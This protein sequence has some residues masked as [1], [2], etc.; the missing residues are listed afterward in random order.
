MRALFSLLCLLSTILFGNPTTTK[1]QDYWEYHELIN[2]AEKHISNENF[3]EALELY[4]LTFASYDFVFIRDYKIAAQLAVYLNEKEKAFEI[5][6]KGI[7]AGWDF[8][9]LKRN[10]YLS[11]LKGE[12]EWKLL[13]KAYPELRK[14]YLKSI[15]LVTKERVR[16]MFKE[17]QR[18]ALGAL[19]RIGDKSQEKYALEKFAPHSEI[20]M[21]KLIKILDRYGYPGEQLIGNNFWMS[22]ILSHHNSI[23][24]E[25][26]KKDTLYHVIKPKLVEAIGKGQIS[27]YEFALIDDWYR[28]V[29]SDRLA[30]GYGFLNPPLSSSLEQTNILRRSIALRSIELRNKLIA[31]EIKTGMYFYLP[32]WLEGEIKPSVD[33]F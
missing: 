14:E 18:K 1:K 21:S 11:K 25:Y 19:F 31:I 9:E 7:V 27:P 28:A 2:N 6:K 22:T 20:Q 4:E 30:V 10:N 5:I 8:K 33:E 29:Y 26:V 32:D 3:K 15:D 23:A 16:Q 13:K 12:D 17:D 24:N